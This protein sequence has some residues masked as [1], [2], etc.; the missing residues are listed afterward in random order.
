M[1]AGTTPLVVLTGVTINDPALQMVAVRP[2]Q[3]YRI[4]GQI[5]TDRLTTRNGILLE[6]LG[7]RCPTLA[8]R[9]EVVTGTHDWRPLELAFTTPADCSLVKIGI[10][11][12]RSEK[13]D[14]KISGD[15][16]LDD[17]RMTEIKN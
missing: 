6:V 15:V 9:S 8:A 7:D 3:Q 2:K 17:F 1:P 14:N 5:R 11:R 10:K 13:F 12:E 16:W 4:S